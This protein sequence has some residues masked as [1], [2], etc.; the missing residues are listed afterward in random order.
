M[1]YQGP[2][3]VATFQF[4][5]PFTNNTDQLPDAVM[6]AI[7]QALDFYLY[8]GNYTI[9][10]A[11]A[12]LAQRPVQK[13]AKYYAQF[14]TTVNGV[15][16]PLSVNELGGVFIFMGGTAAVCLL[17]QASSRWTDTALKSET[18]RIAISAVTTRLGRRQSQIA[19]TVVEEEGAEKGAVVLESGGGGG[20]DKAP[21]PAHLHDALADAG[22][23]AHEEH[24]AAYG[25]AYG[26]G[27]VALREELWQLHR[28]KRVLIRALERMLL[29]A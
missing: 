5:I 20:V 3:S 4:G 12:Y 14:I 17:M 8:S 1:S 27:D 29:K 28:E 10:T 18:V 7:N 26:G 24:R 21:H 15:F 11:A 22:A 23:D 19:A 13:C 9:Q 6:N 25:G 2:P 16:P